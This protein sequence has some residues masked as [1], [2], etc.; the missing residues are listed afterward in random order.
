MLNNLSQRTKLLG[1]F[2]A[3]ALAGAISGGAALVGLKQVNEQAATLYEKHLLGLAAIK[4][5]E[6]HLIQVA[7]FRAQFARAS[8]TA[9]R[10]KYRQL[11]EKNLIITQEALE[12]ATPTLV[13]QRDQQA[14]ERVKANLQAYQPHGRAF[15]DA[16]AQTPLP[17]HSAELDSLNKKAIE[18]FKVVTDGMDALA[19]QKQEVGGLA[20]KKVSATYENVWLL[21]TGASIFSAGLALALGWWLA[22]RLSRQL[23]G[24]PETAASIARH[25]AS[26]DLTQAAIAPPGDVDSVIG[27]MNQMQHRLA[28]VVAGIRVAADSIAVA[29]GQIASGNSDLSYQIGRAHV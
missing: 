8:T 1:A 27:S 5:A 9:E 20:A 12:R 10:E 21:V 14:L 22:H 7:R 13:T 24:E 2:F 17:P 11:F 23:G 6:G 4:D 26:G 29:S 18:T 19:K 25:V 15:V 28:E 3:V 16:V